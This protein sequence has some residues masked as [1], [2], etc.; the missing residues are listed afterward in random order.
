VAERSDE[1]RASAVDGSFALLEEARSQHP[2][3]EFIH[4]DPAFGLPDA[5]R[6]GYDRIEPPGLP[7]GG[8]RW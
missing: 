4:A 1:N 6:R 5:A 3:I 8:M 7:R 2:D